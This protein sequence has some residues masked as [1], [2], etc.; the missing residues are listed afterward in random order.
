VPVA[1]MVG[2][3]VRHLLGSYLASGLYSGSDSI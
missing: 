3:L 2:V 1:A